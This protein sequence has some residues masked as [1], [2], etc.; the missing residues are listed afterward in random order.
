MDKSPVVS[1]IT[2]TYN[3]S[4]V[5]AFTI[6]SVRQSNFTDWELW[7]IG[8]SCTDD[9]EKVVASFNDPRIHF[10][11]LEQNF[12]E[13]SGPNNQ[14]F[15]YCQGRYIAYLNH[16]DLWL[17]NHL[18]TVVGAIEETGAD[19]VYTLVSEIQP[20]GKVTLAGATPS[21][22][23]DPHI[24]VPASSWL[25]RRELIEEIGPWRFYKECY[26]IPSQEWIHRA[27]KAGKDLRLVKRMTAIAIQSGNR[28]RVYKKREY[29][30][31]EYYYNRIASEPDIL[32]REL[33]T[34]A[35]CRYASRVIDL[36]VGALLWQALGNIFK[37]I[38]RFLLLRLGIHPQALKYFSIYRSKGGFIDHLRQKRGLDKLEINQE[39]N[40]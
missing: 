3:R 15:E 32:E 18:E 40:S 37:N 14:G 28:D 34:V 38:K 39:K 10:V 29:K 27:S 7:V 4:N 35:A 6:A 36:P 25:L 9:T 1:I 26:N 22:R 11:N 2:A 23:Y 13:Q 17:P 19:L 16:D 21:D 5:L 20:D 12:G 24:F 8:D 30:E 33:L 31:N